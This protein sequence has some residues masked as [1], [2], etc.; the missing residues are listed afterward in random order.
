MALATGCYDTAAVRHLLDRDELRHVSCER[1][2]SATWN[3]P[4]ALGFH[5]SERT[6]DRYL[7]GLRPQPGSLISAGRHFLPITVR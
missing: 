5:I 6:V 4:N 7:R 1:S 3:L 2:T